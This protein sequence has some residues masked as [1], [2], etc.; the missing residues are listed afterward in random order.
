MAKINIKCSFIKTYSLNYIALCRGDYGQNWLNSFIWGTHTVLRIIGLF[1]KKQVY[2]MQ[3]VVWCLL[4][5]RMSMQKLCISIL[6]EV[7][8][9]TT[10]SGLSYNAQ[11]SCLVPSLSPTYHFTWWL[12]YFVFPNKSTT[13]MYKYFTHSLKIYL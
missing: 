1:C 5:I 11:C 4:A 6:Y 9:I 8:T 10:H 13:K 7:E 3:I 12:L 2:V